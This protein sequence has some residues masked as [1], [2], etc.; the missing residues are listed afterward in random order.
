MEARILPPPSP[1]P[2]TSAS[3]ANGSSSSASS[4]ATRRSR[5]R[6]RARPGR[7]ARARR[8][9]PEDRPARDPGRGGPS[10]STSS[11]TS[12]RSSSR[13]GS[14]RARGAR[15]STRSCARTSPTATADCRGRSSSSSATAA[16]SGG[17]S[18]SCSTR[19]SGTARSA[20]CGR[21]SARTST[22]T[23]PLALL[24]DPT[25]LD[26]PMHQ[27]REEISAGFERL[28]ER[29]ARSR[30]RPRRGRASGPGRP[31][32]AATSRTLLEA[33]LGDIAR[34]AG[35]LRRPDR[36]R[37]RRR[38]PLQEGR[39]RRDDQPG[40]RA[41]PTFGSSSRPRTGRCR[42]AR[43]ARSS[44]RRARTAAP[45]SGSSSSA[46]PRPGGHR[47]V[48]RPRRR[49]LLRHRSGRAG[50]G[51]LEAAFRLARLLAIASL[52]EREVGGRRR[53]IGRALA[54]CAS[55]LE[56]LKGVKATLTSIV[57]RNE[58]GLVGPRR[59]PDGRSSRGWR[60]P[61][62]RSGSRGTTAR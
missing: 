21:S 57:E 25:R 3:T 8:A 19:R 45:P 47:P 54:G 44:A 24:L 61:R 33:L 13:H 10:T 16:R 27:F 48:R 62:R 58:G 37:D 50:P 43:S 30:P 29:L 46:R 20:G 36:R 1:T 41:A 34:G 28:N 42:C 40:G 15:R 35:D 59:D 11:A 53:A 18:P 22:A 17:S 9:R 5:P 38:A 23:S 4:S 2:P 12:S 32:R 60:T 56:A 55:E 31:P 51:H 6:R 14:Q 39:L 52:R 49:R 7:P 26:S